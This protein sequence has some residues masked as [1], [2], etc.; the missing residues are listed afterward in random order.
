MEII[1]KL[2]DDIANNVYK[3]LGKHPVAELYDQAEEYYYELHCWSPH[4]NIT[5]CILSDKRK[6]LRQSTPSYKICLLV[7]DLIRAYNGYQEETSQSQHF[8]EW[9]FR[10]GHFRFK[11][12]K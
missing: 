7:S 8:S 11:L 1:S 6:R 5:S 9:A 4:T 12:A 3:F 2:P 10:N